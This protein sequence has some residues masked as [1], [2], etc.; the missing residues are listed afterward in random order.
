VDESNCTLNEIDMEDDLS[1]SV[2]SVLPPPICGPLPSGPP[3]RNVFQTSNIPT[4][5]GAVTSAGIYNKVTVNGLKQ[6]S[7]D[8]T[9]RRS[10]QSY[11]A[12]PLLTNRI[13]PVLDENA[14]GS[15]NSQGRYKEKS[16]ARAIPIF[17]RKALSNST[18]SNS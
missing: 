12:R 7:K 5:K 11:R 4:R 2:A 13:N 10:R 1:I 15:H 3:T 8:C 18:Q 9:S 6:E 17:K 14:H 16:F